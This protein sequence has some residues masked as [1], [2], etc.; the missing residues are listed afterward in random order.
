MKENSGR[1][2]PQFPL[3]CFPVNLSSAPRTAFPGSAVFQALIRKLT[4]ENNNVTG[5]EA[6]GAYKGIDPSIWNR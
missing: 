1:Q 6:P 3:A 2:G 5:T 4:P